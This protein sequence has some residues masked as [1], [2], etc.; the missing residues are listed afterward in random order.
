MWKNLTHVE[1]VGPGDRRGW[2]QNK[3]G[4]PNTAE[5][6]EVLASTAMVVFRSEVVTFIADQRQSLK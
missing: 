6:V 5:A 2:T 4:G 1:E 3:V